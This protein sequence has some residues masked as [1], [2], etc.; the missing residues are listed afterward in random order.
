MERFKNIAQ[1]ID[2]GGSVAEIGADHAKLI[3]Y[4][5]EQGLCDRGIATELNDG[6]FKRVSEAVAA[7]PYREKVLLRKGD[8]LRILQPG[9]VDNVII[10]GLGGETI[11]EILAYDLDLAASF[12][13]YVLQPMSRSGVLR[14]FLSLRGWP[15]IQEKIVKNKH[16]YYTIIQ[17]RPGD[18]PY[19]LDLPEQEM[20][21]TVLSD[22]GPAGMDYLF[23]QLAR[24]K[25]VHKGLK[26]AN[27][28]SAHNEIVHYKSLIDWLEEKINASS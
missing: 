10:A 15:V 28:P 12:N 11:V 5:L 13:N 20:G 27:I 25:K 23:S 17:V 7:S 22:P 9:E 3:L 2:S 14:R 26:A 24:Y 18:T 19:R 16:H 4:L 1:M 6:P 21:M 8:G